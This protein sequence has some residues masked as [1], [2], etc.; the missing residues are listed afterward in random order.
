MTEMQAK[1]SSADADG[2]AVS[3]DK[4]AEG[5][6]TSPKVAEPA[7]AAEATSEAGKPA[8][9]I[10]RPAADKPTRPAG[11][12]ARPIGRAVVTP[13]GEKPLVSGVKFSRPAG[14][15]S[16]PDVAPLPSQSGLSSTSPAVA[17][18]SVRS[19]LG[20]G[21]TTGTATSA[22]V[23]ATA[24]LGGS[25]AG[26]AN[27]STRVTE[28]VRAARATVT[29]AARRGPRRARLHLRRIDPWSVMKFAFAVSFV[30][31]IVVI[32]ATS[33]LYLALDAMGVFGSVNTALADLVKGSGGDAKSLKITAKMVIGGAAMIGVVN[34]VLFTALATLGA[35]IYNVCADLVGGI[36]LTFAEKD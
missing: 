1:A 13:T 8:G 3:S 36:E 23:G 34:V 19:S 4:P 16:P 17:R 24:G 6:S 26:S 9:E 18:A 27:A 30:L 29:A 22:A 20:S 10:T 25:A 11:V 14:M 2:P 35:F 15:P 5:S 32:V 31:F 33:V 28:A 7:K 12:T 21:G